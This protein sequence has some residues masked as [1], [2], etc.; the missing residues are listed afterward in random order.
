MSI[1]FFCKCKEGISVHWKGHCSDKD[2]LPVEDHLENNCSGLLKND[3]DLGKGGKKEIMWD[4]QI[5]DLS[6]DGA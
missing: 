6:E 4:C 1:R 3:N 2:H 5:P